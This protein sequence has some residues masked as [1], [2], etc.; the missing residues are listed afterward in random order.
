MRR[1]PLLHLL[2]RCR[3]HPLLVIGDLMLDHWVWGSVS[4]ISPEA[5]IPVV[6]VQRYTY[7]PGGAANVVTNLRALGVPVH[8]MGVVG[9]DDAGR[10]LR[11]LLRREGAEVSGILTDDSR[12][13]SLKT[14]IVAHSQQMVRADYESRAPLD[15]AVQQRLLDALAQHLPEVSMVVFSDYDKGMFGGPD[16]AQ[17][18]LQRAQHAGKCV[19]GGPK[20]RN[21]GHF[22]GARLVT[23]NAS[24]AGQASGYAT[25]TPEGVQQAGEELRRRLPG[26]HVVITRGE[27]GMSL[28]QHDGPVA[29]AP[30]LA[31]QVFDVSGAG[32]TVLATLACTLAAG[33]T[34][35]QAIDIASHAAAVVV[36][37]VGTAV[38]SSQEIAASYTEGS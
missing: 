20:P 22:Q 29:H 32:D 30:A 26:T 38:A 11:T 15:P 10:R 31:T 23:L 2:E 27:Q 18:L 8:L 12:P 14:R 3:A 28:F 21:F 37:K 17:G 35:V 34:P 24:E 13:T 16:F 33:A 36:R 5:P 6:D 1:E 9:K 25:G 4:R 19:V 7:T